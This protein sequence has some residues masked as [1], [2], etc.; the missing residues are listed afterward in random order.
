MRP[1]I[2]AVGLA[3]VTLVICCAIAV[4]LAQPRAHSQLHNAYWPFSVETQVRDV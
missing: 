4:C 3:L 2:G 1:L